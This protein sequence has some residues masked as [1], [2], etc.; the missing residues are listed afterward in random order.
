MAIA[1][2]LAGGK[3]EVDLVDAGSDGAVVAALVDD[4]PGVD[5]G[6]AAIELL[7][8]LLGPGHL[9]DP[10]GMYEADRLHARYSGVSQAVAEFGADGG[11]KRGRLVL[12]PVA[13]PDVTD[14]YRVHYPFAVGLVCNC[15]PRTLVWAAGNRQQGR[16]G[17]PPGGQ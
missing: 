14:R 15:T 16:K 10:P 12:E 7:G 2:R 3:R 1:E 13:R 9:R 8:D 17:I 4:Q 11:Q 6:A 5:R